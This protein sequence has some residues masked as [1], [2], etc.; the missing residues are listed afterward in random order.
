MRNDLYQAKP[1]MGMTIHKNSTEWNGHCIRVQSALVPRYFWTS[2]SVD[3]YVDQSCVIKTGGVFRFSGIETGDLNDRG[4]N[5]VMQ[6]AWNVGGRDLAVRYELAIDGHVLL[7]SRVFPR[8]WPLLIFPLAGLLLLV[9]GGH[10]LIFGY[11]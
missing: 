9:F 5:H 8:N 1:A 4:K 6:M 7:K 3:A 2:A 10:L 11:V